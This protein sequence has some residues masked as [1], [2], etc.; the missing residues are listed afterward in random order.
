[1]D[2]ELQMRHRD[3]PS[4]APGKDFQRAVQPKAGFF[5][6]AFFC[7]LFFARAKKSESPRGRNRD[8]TETAMIKW[9]IPI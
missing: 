2:A 4:A 9:T 5:G 1:M 6:R 8:D 3:V 7:L